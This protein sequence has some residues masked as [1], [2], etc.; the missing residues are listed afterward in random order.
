MDSQFIGSVI[1]A[2]PLENMISGPL[3]AMINAQIQAS[4]AY[5]DFLLSVCI[6]NNKAVAIQFDYDE[7]LIDE[8]GVAKGMVTKTMRIPLIAAI[9][10]PIISIEEGTIDF[11]LEVTQSESLSDDTGEDG[12]LAASLGW[13][14]FKVKMAGRVSHKSTQTRSTDTRAK[15]SIHT[16]VKRQAAPEALM[17]VIDFLTDAVTRPSVPG[18][19]MTSQ[20]VENAIPT[21]PIEQQEASS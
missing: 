18:G 13:G 4:K 12:N 8:S 20:T 2:L 14:P 17:R 19:E 16:Q 21:T 3:Q 6:Q 7:T 11:E 15:Y 1:N 5:T 9:T 10:H